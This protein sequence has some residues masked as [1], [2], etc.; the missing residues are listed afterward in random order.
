MAAPTWTRLLKLWGVGV[1]ILFDEGGGEPPY[2]ASL[3][4]P[5]QLPLSEE[6]PRGE[7]MVVVGQLVWLYSAI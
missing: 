6:G 4:R 7:P 3:E 2:Q 5:F 1:T